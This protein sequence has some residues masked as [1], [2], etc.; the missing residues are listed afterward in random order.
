MT[1]SPV[2]KRQAL[3]NNLITQ[4]RKEWLEQND[5]KDG[6]DCVTPYDV[7]FYDDS[8][9]PASER[10]FVMGEGSVLTS[11]GVWSGMPCICFGHA[12]EAGPLGGGAEQHRELL[13]SEGITVAFSTLA[14][15]ECWLKLTE[16]AAVAYTKWCEQ[17]KKPD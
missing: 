12:P 14:S 17:K 5:P 11:A 2:M 3:A 9:T 15:M 13:L 1:A 6:T 7:Y 16:N 10:I 8:G 4:A